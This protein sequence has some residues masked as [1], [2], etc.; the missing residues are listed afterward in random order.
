MILTGILAGSLSACVV[1]TRTVAAPPPPPAKKPFTI[2][3]TAEPAPTTQAAVEETAEPAE[4]PV[5]TGNNVAEGRPPAFKDGA[6]EAYWVWHDRGGWHV[7]TTTA[8]QQHRFQGRVWVG[9]GEVMDVHPSHNELGDRLVQRGNFL[10]FDFTTKG[11]EDGFDFRI[12]DG[13]CAKFNLL[14]D[15]RGQP[16]RIFVGGQGLMPTKHVFKVCK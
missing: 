16:D 9:K 7:R 11:H 2:T 13:E 12:A 6:P 10:T 15:H 4:A 8:H 1:E 5:D 14:I 3:R